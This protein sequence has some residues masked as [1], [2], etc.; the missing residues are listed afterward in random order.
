MEKILFAGLAKIGLFKAKVKCQ[1]L[2]SLR[3][4]VMVMAF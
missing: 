3:S 4:I 1:K 2:L